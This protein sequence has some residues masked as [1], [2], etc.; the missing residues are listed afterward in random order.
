MVSLASGIMLNGVKGRMGGNQHLVRSGAAIRAQGGVLMSD[1]SRVQ[2]DPVLV[3]RSADKVKTLA[4]Q[5]GGL[6]WS[7]DV[8]AEIASAKNHIFFDTAT[9]QMRPTLLEKAINAGKH[10]YC[11]KPIATN[12]A[13]A[14]KI[15]RRAQPKGI[16]NG[17]VQDKLFLPGLQKIKMLRDSGFFGRIF[18]VRGEFGYWGFE[19]DWQAAQRRSRNYRTEAGGGMALDLNCHWG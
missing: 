1:G 2:L 4:E 7:T 17:T 18:S 19:G 3:S 5:H 14:L 8:D 12:L 11:E 13:E 16:K 6:R 10:I 9:T 15:C